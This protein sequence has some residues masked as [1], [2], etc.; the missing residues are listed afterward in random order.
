LLPGDDGA[1]V[2]RPQHL[3]PTGTVLGGLFLRHR[4]IV[5]CHRQLDER[6][7]TGLEPGYILVHQSEPVVHLAEPGAGIDRIQRGRDRL[8]TPALGQCQGRIQRRHARTGGRIQILLEEKHPDRAIYRRIEAPLQR[9]QPLLEKCHVALLEA[10]F[11]LGIRLA[12]LVG[13]AIQTLRRRQQAGTGGI[14]VIP[15]STRGLRIFQAQGIEPG[16]GFGKA[17]IRRLGSDPVTQ[18]RF[19]LTPAIDQACA[20]RPFDLAAEILH[21]IVE[22]GQQTLVLDACIR[23]L[24]R[25]LL[26][27]P[28]PAFEHPDAI[29]IAPAKGVLDLDQPGI[30]LGRTRIAGQHDEITL[31]ETSR[32]NLQKMPGLER[33]IGCCIR[34]AVA[35]CV[36]IGPIECKVAR[37]PRPHPVVDIATVAA[38]I[39]TGRVGQAHIL[40]LEPVDQLVLQTAKETRHLAAV[41]GLLFTLGNDFL[42]TR[43]NRG[44]YRC[45]IH[46]GVQVLAHALGHILDTDR[47]VNPRTGRGRQLGM[48]ID[49][50]KTIGQIVVLGRGIELDRA[51]RAVMVGHHQ[52]F[53]RDKAG[54]AATQ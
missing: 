26:D 54:G 32:R 6:I 53:W 34:G 20:P 30:A 27:G 21:R 10:R 15:G 40:D 48:T 45:A 29:R 16:Q 2:L 37:V 23:A 9:L 3:H 46:L 42:P 25:S 41:T 36:D 4:V 5:Q 13:Q 18:R 43:V 38:D 31:V 22:P 1:H 12:L 39:V 19:A 44:K 11:S 28:D 33:N 8:T 35:L 49:G 47:H 14:V 52:P 50:Q 17:R 51:P 24:G 7:I